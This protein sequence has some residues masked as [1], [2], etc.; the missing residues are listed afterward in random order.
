MLNQNQIQEIVKCAKRQC[1][2]ADNH[3]KCQTGEEKLGKIRT[4]DNES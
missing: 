1:K 3:R 2:N 4:T